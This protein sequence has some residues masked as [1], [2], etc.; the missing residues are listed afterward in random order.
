MS[1]KVISKINKDEEVQVADVDSFSLPSSNDD[2]VDDE[3]E[4]TV[5]NQTK[6]GAIPSPGS[7]TFGTSSSSSSTSPSTYVQSP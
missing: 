1:K 2:E 6:L 3:T 4:L 7:T 5:P